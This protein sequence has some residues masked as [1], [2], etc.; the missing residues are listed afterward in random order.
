MVHANT[1]FISF[2]PYLNATC[3]SDGSEV[4]SHGQSHPRIGQIYSSFLGEFCPPQ[5][6][7]RW[8]GRAAGAGGV[9]TLG[10]DQITWAGQFL[11]SRQRIVNTPLATY[12]NLLDFFDVAKG[13]GAKK[14]WIWD[15]GWWNNQPSDPTLGE[16]HRS[17]SVSGRA[18]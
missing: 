15:E 10:R 1:G 11:V 8:N 2:G 3:K 5:F 14:G 13:E 18:A 7:V 4:D 6:L 12:Q 16:H 9:L 17:N